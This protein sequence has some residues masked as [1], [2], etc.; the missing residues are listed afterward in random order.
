M[1]RLL[2]VGTFDTPHAGHAVF[3]R[4]C[5]RF[6]DHVTVVVRTDDVVGRLRGRFPVFGYDERAALI[7]ALGYEVLPS[8][9]V[10][11]KEIIEEVRPSVLAIG[12]DWA[13]EDWL[14]RIGVDQDYLDEHGIA[15][16]YVPYTPNISTTELKR[17]LRTL[18]GEQS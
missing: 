1:S 8:W 2:T 16:I 12:S 10:S 5:E 14:D 11:V 15:L 17:R 13:R 6:A 18:P 4:K 7:N 3:L 9:D